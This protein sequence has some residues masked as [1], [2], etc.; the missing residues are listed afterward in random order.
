MKMLDCKGKL[1]SKG[2]MVS[3]LFDSFYTWTNEE[4]NVLKVTENWVTLESPN[5]EVG[6]TLIR[7]NC[8]IK[9]NK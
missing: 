8:V 1:I 3:P 2:D 4:Y 9:R 7:P 5:S 6:I